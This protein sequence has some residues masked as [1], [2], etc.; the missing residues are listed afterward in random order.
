M[1]KN[2]SYGSFV[3]EK[4]TV[5]HAPHSACILQE[6]VPKSLSSLEHCCH[7]KWQFMPLSLQSTP[8]HLFFLLIIF[9]FH[10]LK[11]LKVSVAS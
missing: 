4:G 7:C 11:A 8:S 6:Q 3:D 5:A 2:Q 9:S 10:L 1:N